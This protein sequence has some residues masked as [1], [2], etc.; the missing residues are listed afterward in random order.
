[1]DGFYVCKIQK[2]SDKVKTENEESQGVEEKLDKDANNETTVEKSA[3]SK[4][5]EKSPHKLK[6]GKKKRSSPQDKLPTSKKP[7]TE[8][9]SIPPPSTMKKGGTNKKNSAKTT[10][11]RRIRPEK[12]M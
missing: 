11:P 9:V 10:K 2:L 1:M 6:Q 8:K 3:P 12:A 5:K 4:Q 7:K